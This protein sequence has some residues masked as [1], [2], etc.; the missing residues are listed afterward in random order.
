MISVYCTYNRGTQYGMRF[1][2]AV[3]M[4]QAKLLYPFSFTLQ[5]ITAGTFLIILPLSM[6]WSSHGSGGRGTS[7]CPG[8]NSGAVHYSRCVNNLHWWRSIG[9]SD[10]CKS[11]QLLWKFDPV[12][13]WRIRTYIFFT[14]TAISIHVFS[15]TLQ[16]YHKVRLVIIYFL[17]PL[18][19][20]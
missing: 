18:R 8:A 14:L 6:R 4:I 16:L 10:R 20:L 19:R 15:R 9:A 5:C 17:L 1:P 11:F 12:T 13:T 3:K 2:A 7:V